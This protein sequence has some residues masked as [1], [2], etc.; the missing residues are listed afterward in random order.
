M[1]RICAKNLD[2]SVDKVL[3]PVSFYNYDGAVEFIREKLGGVERGESESSEERSGFVIPFPLT[4]RTQKEVKPDILAG[5][6]SENL[7]QFRP[8][9]GI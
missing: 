3:V 8:W 6:T 7:K 4:I 5:K 2:G 9:A 1:Y